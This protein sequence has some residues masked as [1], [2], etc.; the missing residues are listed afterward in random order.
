MHTAIQASTGKARVSSAVSY[1][2]FWRSLTGLHACMLR[3][4]HMHVHSLAGRGLC[5]LG[6]G[7]LVCAVCVTLLHP[8][9]ICPIFCH[10]HASFQSSPQPE[11][12]GTYTL[13]SCCLVCIDSDPC[14]GVMCDVLAVVQCVW[15]CF[16]ECGKCPAP[17][18]LCVTQVADKAQ[19]LKGH[20]WAYKVVMV[21]G[22][23][24]LTVHARH[25]LHCMVVMMQQQMWA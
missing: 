2:W 14:P 13:Q 4:G 9:P 24:V 8:L 5:V 22:G 20:G 6:A 15:Q 1:V 25:V 16:T 21:F 18:H 19:G 12:A 11:M 17:C 10:M 23:A 3:Q 7:L